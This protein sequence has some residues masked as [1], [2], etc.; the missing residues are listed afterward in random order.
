MILNRKVRDNHDINTAINYDFIEK[1]AHR[2]TFKSIVNELHSYDF[3][4]AITIPMLN[5]LVS[6]KNQI[7][8]P[9]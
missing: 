4:V 2:I 9:R 3:D 8:R 5:T 7:K 6:I 1:I